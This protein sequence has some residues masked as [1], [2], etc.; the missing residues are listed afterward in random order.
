MFLSTNF[1]TKNILMPIKNYFKNKS[2][3]KS[4]EILVQ[5]TSCLDLS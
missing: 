4:S 3:K 1:N 2:Y 5:S